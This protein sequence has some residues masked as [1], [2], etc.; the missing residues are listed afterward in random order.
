MPTIFV[1][2]EGTEIG[3]FD[4]SIRGIT[5][6]LSRGRQRAAISSG[7]ADLFS[8][9][10][11]PRSHEELLEFCAS[12]GMKDPDASLARLL[13]TP[14][15]KA[16]VVQADSANAAASPT[17]SKGGGFRIKLDLINSS[18]VY[19]LSSPLLFFFRPWGLSIGVLFTAL[20]HFF[21]YKAAQTTVSTGGSHIN[22]AIV[23][24][25]VYASVFVHELGHAACCRYFG[26]SPGAV[27][28]GI[29]FFW[30]VLFT[31]LSDCW[32]LNRKER[33]YV[34]CAGMYIQ[35]ICSGF[36]LLIW[37]FLHSRESA[38]VSAS[39]ILSTMINL[40]P[41]FR[42]DGYWLLT[43][44]CGVPHLHKI[45]GHLFRKTICMVPLLSR[46]RLD[47]SEWTWDM[48]LRMQYLLSLY[49]VV[50][51]ACVGY[52]TYRMGAGLWNAL[53]GLASRSQDIFAGL[54]HHIPSHRLLA[55]VFPLL[56]ALVGVIEMTFFIGLRSV[57][58]CRP[59]ATRL[60]VKLRTHSL[61]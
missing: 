21:L 9:L 28:V 34:D 46:W 12:S 31:D 59:I 58:V 11:S 39:I 4:S 5:H 3:R 57:N 25:G 8:F 16:F 55:V 61:S 24:A 40:N 44:L 53:R 35:L 17:D 56:I 33:A 30:P 54:H 27:G 48:S 36:A 41:F 43:D 20:T 50:N 22:L 13:S 14:A 19:R 49:F 26:S 42:F 10:K 51:C 47:V 32:K 15:L 2:L 18:L 6:Q 23:V 38:V 45:S 7:V 1:A 60:W 29:Y 37:R 52:W